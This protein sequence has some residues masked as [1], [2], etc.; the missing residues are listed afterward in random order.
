M[1]HK[2]SFTNLDK[3]SYK[4][5]VEILTLKN[6]LYDLITDFILHKF[7]VS[8]EVLEV[9]CYVVQMDFFALCNVCCFLQITII[10]ICVHVCMVAILRALNSH[11]Y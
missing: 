6:I 9:N 1:E 4:I 8:P 5:Y 7:L 2:N 3:V 10:S 11:S